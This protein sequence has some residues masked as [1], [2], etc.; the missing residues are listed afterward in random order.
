V[1]DLRTDKLLEEVRQALKAEACRAARRP[2]PLHLCLRLAWSAMPKRSSPAV[3]RLCTGA[4][5][6]SAV[7]RE[8]ART[9]PAFTRH[10][11][12]V[13]ARRAVRLGA[14]TD[15]RCGMKFDDWLFWAAFAGFVGCNLA[16]LMWAALG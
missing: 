16:L 9:W 7:R 15:D 2:Q 12:P 10:S 11:P 4:M 6:R 3:L 1:T 5:R 14:L 13:A 8:L